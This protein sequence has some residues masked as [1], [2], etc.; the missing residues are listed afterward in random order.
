MWSSHNFSVTTAFGATVHARRGASEVDDKSGTELS[1]SQLKVKVHK[2]PLISAFFLDISK[3]I[4][5]NILRSLKINVLSC[6][7]LD[8][9]LA[10]V[11]AKNMSVASDVNLRKMFLERLEH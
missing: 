5:L 4:P 10:L 2:S 3:S 7:T 6:S 9:Y 8:E 11:W 1:M